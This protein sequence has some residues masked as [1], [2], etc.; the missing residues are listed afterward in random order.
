[1]KNFKT[2]KD[3]PVYDLEPEL[4]ELLSS[5]KIS[6]TSDLQIGV[7]VTE[8]DSYDYTEASGSL[9]LDWNNQQKVIDENGNEKI[10][11]PEFKYPK[12]EKDFLYLCNIFKDTSFEEIFNILQKKYKLG[13][14][15]IMKS[16]PKT[17]LSWHVDYYKRIH[18]PIKTQAGCLMIIEDEVCELK[19]GQWWDTNTI[20]PHTAVNAS[21][22]DRIHLVATILD[23]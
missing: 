18:L 13:R 14:L 16:K 15:R 22:E 23:V 11:I 19:S 6:W 7:N 1:M 10:V 8:T 9:R 12:E 20:V 3:L 21:K 5:N 2:I 17:C 4:N